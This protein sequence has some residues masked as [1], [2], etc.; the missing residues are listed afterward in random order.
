[1][2]KIQH[3]AKPALTTL[4]AAGPTA[5]FPRGLPLRFPHS[6][7]G[8]IVLLAAIMADPSGG[9]ATLVYAADS[10]GTAA[11]TA[12]LATIELA[13]AAQGVERI[14][15]HRGAMLE[16]P[17]NTI[18]AI[19]RAIEAGATAVEIDIR[20]SRD[21][22]LVLMHDAK[23]DRTTDGTGR[24]SDLSWAELMALDAGSSFDPKYAAERVPSLEQTLKA[25]RGRIDVQLD[26]KEDGAAYADRIAACVKAH[27]E[28]SRIMVAVQSVKQAH[29]IK[30]RLP[31]V[32]TLI[33]LRKK[34]NL[35][36]F[37]A[38]KVDF[39]RPQIAWLE[40]DPNLL[41]KIR[42]G[43]A[44]IHFD[45]TTGTTEKVLPLLKYQPESLLSDDPAQLVKTLT[46]LQK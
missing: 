10:P 3:S 31:Q 30:E 42:E 20:T 4:R 33:F 38:A 7:A 22:R 44:K 5:N 6:I 25:C 17:E 19:E 26:L 43:G 29:Q 13:A 35:D 15:A 9:L 11:A 37:L 40:D 46:Q 28:P 14:V 8:C 32:S 23:V 21:G 18:A 12:E 1:M 27:G 34:K 39:L 16:R 36:A 41:A 45:V 2:F 24:V